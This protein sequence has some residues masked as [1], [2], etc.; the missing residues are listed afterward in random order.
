[1]DKTAADTTHQKHAS[2]VDDMLDMRD[3]LSSIRDQLVDMKT[4]AAG[5]AA[6]VKDDMCKTATQVVID[7]ANLGDLIRVFH[8]CTDVP[9]YAKEA[10]VAVRDY[11]LERGITQE[12]WYQLKTA[13]VTGRVNDSHPLVA[14]FSA[15][16]KA[17]RAL[18]IVDGAL[19]NV[20]DR[21]RDVNRAVVRSVN[22]AP[23]NHRG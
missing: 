1:M 8:Q 13:H 22:D 12:D 19:S 4:G 3:V 20:Q 9:A 23:L 18:K 17:A 21:I 11:L 5:M 7:G 15:F 14:Q 2:P 16:V 10:A 6:F